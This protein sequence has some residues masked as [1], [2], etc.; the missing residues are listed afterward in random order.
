MGK[1]IVWSM[2]PD[3]IDRELY[4]ILP[5]G[6][7]S[8][9]K[10]EIEE[11][12]KTSNKLL[13]D[14]R[15]PLDEA[16]NLWQDS[17]KDKFDTI[18]SDYAKASKEIDEAYRAL[19]EK[20]RALSDDYQSKKE[21]VWASLSSF[22]TYNKVKKEIEPKVEALLSFKALTIKSIREKYEARVS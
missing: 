17:V 18:E 4:E 9:F 16:I 19:E 7:K 8:R 20:R 11:T 13:Q 10:A 6:V 21:E 1:K 2:F 22:E 3:K 15:K 12:L 14:Y 5:S